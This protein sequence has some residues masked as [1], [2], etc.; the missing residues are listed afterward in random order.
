VLFVANIDANL[1]SVLLGDEDRVRQVLLNL[2]NNAAKYTAEGTIT[3]TVTQIEDREFPPKIPPRPGDEETVMIAYEIADTGSGIKREDMEKLFGDYVQFDLKRSRGA[4]GTG[5]GLAISRK[6]ISFMGGNITARSTYGQG[7]VFRVTLPQKVIDRK[8]LA[9]VNHPKNKRVL[10]YEKRKPLGEA[11]LQTLKNLGV[12]CALASSTD[13]Y[14]QNLSS[15]LWELAGG[16]LKMPLTAGGDDD[17]EGNRLSSFVFVTP[18]LLEE[19][20]QILDELSP[21]DL[22]L[23]APDLGLALMADYNDIRWPGI[24]CLS[25]PL[26]PWN[27]ANLLNGGSEY[28]RSPSE[29]KPR[30][31]FIAPE[32]R[33]LIVDDIV[34]NITVAEGLLAHYNMQIDSCV[35]GPTAVQLAEENAYDIIFMDHMMPGMDGIETTAAIRALSRDYVLYMPIVALTANAVLG[36]REMFLDQGFDDY[37]SKPINIARLDEI[38]G[39]WIPLSKRR[40]KNWNAVPGAGNEN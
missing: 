13:E 29:E 4:E 33:V 18:G 20:R 32:A 37:L 11:A 15:L 9:A 35:D 28:P 16:I 10:V 5:L 22:S 8:P 2:L 38:I 27:T 26:R 40:R 31:R 14:R 24:P 1:P 21:G 25:V 12:P 30:P 3:F 19:S 23:D 7:S 6:L 34:T 39:K 36:M 17:D